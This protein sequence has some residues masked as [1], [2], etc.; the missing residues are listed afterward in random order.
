MSSLDATLLLG[1]ALANTVAFALMGID[2]HRARQGSW[3]IPE[4]TLLLWCALFGSVGGW[5][6]M[7]TFRHKTRH[8]KF[9]I[10]VPL[11]A[12]LQLVLLIVYFY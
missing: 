9:T 12:L 4:G 2:K 3:R 5:L 10:A 8:T 11:M 6:G 1:V 7:R